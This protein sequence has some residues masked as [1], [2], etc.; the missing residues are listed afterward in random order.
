MPWF[1]GVN[2]KWRNY[3]HRSG[4]EYLS[5]S[6]TVEEFGETLNESYAEVIAEVEAEN[7]WSADNNYGMTE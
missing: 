1:T 5:D 3:F 4:Q 2:E 6:I 7:G